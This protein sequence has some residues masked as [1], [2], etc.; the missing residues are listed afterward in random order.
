MMI[1]N[2]ASKF[3]RLSTL[4]HAFKAIY[5]LTPQQVDAFI[6][7]YEIYDYDWV[8]GQ[9]MKN[10][11]TIEYAQVKKSLIDWYSVLN[12]LCAMGAVEKMYIPPALDLSQGVIDNQILFERKFAESLHMKAGD[13][14]LE[15]GC[16]KGR[17]AAHLAAL[18]GADIT[19]INI[20]QVQLDNARTFAQKNNLSQQCHFTNADFNDL[21]LAFPDEHFDCMY[22]IQALSLCRDLPK[23]FQELHRVLKP[24]AKISFLEWVRLPNY[25]ANNPHHVTLMQQIKP[26][27]G[28]IGT[29]SPDEYESAL[30]DAGFNI[31]V[32]E[33]P[34]INKSQLPLIN[35]AGDNYEKFMPFI[36]LLVKVKLLP[37]HFIVLIERLEKHVEALCEAD[38]LRLVTMCYHFIAQKNN[39]V[40][41]N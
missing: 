41:K 6:N 9:A 35:Q 3:Y 20:D 15:L 22:E 5:Q 32:S 7:A 18:T 25:S 21:P 26:L 17:V 12:H 34:S 10:S 1:Q 2:P 38:K 4:F 31:L 28:A 11:Q 33:D 23:L 29:P 37:K 13:T 8:H 30:R 36:K 39:T 27:I 14:V 40:E 19:G 16:G 24:G